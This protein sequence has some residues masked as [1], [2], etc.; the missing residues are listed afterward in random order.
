MASVLLFLHERVELVE[1]VERVERVELVGTT[2]FG[3]GGLHGIKSAPLLCVFISF[4]RLNG[5]SA[6]GGHKITSWDIA[7]NLLPGLLTS[8]A[9]VDRETEPRS[10]LK[11]R[12]RTERIIVLFH[13]RYH[14]CRTYK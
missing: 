11:A 3:L 10:K 14:F 13:N 6:E 7:N 4:L 1:R 2:G 8:S 12:S 9:G 5:D